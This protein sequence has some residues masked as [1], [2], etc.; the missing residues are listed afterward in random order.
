MRTSSSTFERGTHAY[1][2][3]AIILGLG[4]TKIIESWV[5]VA[6]SGLTAFDP[7]V[8]SLLATLSLLTIQFWWVI[9]DDTGLGGS[10][11][12]FFALALVEVSIFYALATIL[13][14][15]DQNSEAYRRS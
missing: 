7:G 13:V 15:L 11:F 6:K 10:S 9:F 5:H 3:L 14:P 2:F 12:A 4:V 1:L 8:L